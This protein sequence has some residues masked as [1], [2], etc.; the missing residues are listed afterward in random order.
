MNHLELGQEGE[1]IAIQLLRNKGYDV[2]DQNYRKFRGELDIIASI[3]NT[4]VIVEVKTRNSSAFGEPYRAVAR[5]KQKQ[6]I[7]LANHYIHENEI[8][9][10]VRFDVI[11]IVLNS[12]RQ[13]IDHIEGAFQ[14]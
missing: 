1:R 7:K 5:G 13:K 6:I 14:P 10:E 3:D 9:Q 8:D 12:K 4:L 2:I 11:S